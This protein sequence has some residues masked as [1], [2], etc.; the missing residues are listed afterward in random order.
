MI[1]LLS[2]AFIPLAI[3]QQAPSQPVL[4]I[5]QNY[6]LIEDYQ[7]GV[8]T[9]QSHTERIFDGTD[10]KDFIVYDRS[11]IIQVE[12]N[13]IGSLVYD[14][15]NCSYSI[16][17]NGYVTSGTQIIPSVSWMPRI[18]EVGTD[19]YS[20]MT[21]LFNQQCD[22]QVR[23]GEDWVK[24]TSIK[25][26]TEDLPPLVVQ[27]LNGTSSTYSQGVTQVATTTQT[28]D[29]RTDNGIKE[30]V[31][32]F[33]GNPE[34]SN[35]KF[36]LTQTIH[37]GAEITLAD[38]TYD[39]AAASGT[40]LDRNW[41]ENNEAEIFE[42]AD[43]LNYDMDVGFEQFNALQ[44]IDDGGVYKVALDYSVNVVTPIGSYYEVDPTLSYADESSW[45]RVRTDAHTGS[46][47]NGVGTTLFTGGEE[48]SKGASGSSD[49]C[50]WIGYE[51]DISSIS[52]SAVVSDVQFRI[53]NSNAQGDGQNETCYLVPFDEA[54]STIS[55]A[56]LMTDI[57][58][59]TP[60]AS[61]TFCQSAN[62]QTVFDLGTTA[63]TDA[64]NDLSSGGLFGVGVRYSTVRDSVDNNA[65]PLSNSQL[66]IEYSIPTQ[67]SAPANLSAVSGI[68]IA[69]DWDASTD[70][71]GAATGDMT[72][73][74][75][76]ADYE[77][78]QQ[79]LPINAGSDSAVNM[80]TNVLLYHLDEVESV[81]GG[82]TT[83]TFNDEFTSDQGWTITQA[84]SGADLNG[85]NS[86]TLEFYMP[87]SNG[88]GT[89]YQDYIDLGVTLSTDYIV[90]F[91][92]NHD[93]V[94]ST[95]TFIGVS[96]SPTS[97]PTGGNENFQGVKMVSNAGTPYWQGLAS[98]GVCIGSCYTSWAG[99]E[100]SSGGNWASSTTD[101]MEIIASGGTLTVSEYADNTYSGTPTS[102]T[103]TITSGNQGGQTYFVIKN[104]EFGS[105]WG[106]GA[107]GGYIDNLRVYNGATSVTPHTTTYQIE[108]TSGANNDSENPQVTGMVSSDAQWDNLGTS[109]SDS[110]SG[111]VTKSGSD[112]WSS[113]A[114]TTQT[115][116][117]GSP[118]SVETSATSTHWVFGIMREND[119]TAW[120][121]NNGGQFQIHP[122]W[123]N[124]F[125]V[126]DYS[127]S[128]SQTWSFS[129]WS[130]SDVFKIEVDA[131]GN[132]TFYQNGNQLATSGIGQ[133]TG[134]YVGGVGL[135]TSGVATMDVASEI[136]VNP[137][138]STGTIANQIDAPQLT[139]KSTSLYD[140]TDSHTVG[141][142]TSAITTSIVY[143]E[144]TSDTTEN[145]HIQVASVDQSGGNSEDSRAGVKI[146]SSSHGIVG[147][148]L[149]KVVFKLRNPFSS[150]STYEITAKVWDSSGSV[151]GTSG[152]IVTL[153]QLQTS[154][155]GDA[156]KV[157][158]IFDP[159]VT[160]AQDDI[161]GIE[162][163]SGTTDTDS[164][165]F[166]INTSNV[167]SDSELISYRNGAWQSGN[168]F[169]N[170]DPYMI[171][172]TGSSPS[173]TGT[174]LSFENTAGDTI[175]YEI[176]TDKVRVKKASST[177][178]MDT[179]S[180]TLGADLH[181]YGSTTMRGEKAETSSSALIG[182]TAQ[183][184][185]FKLK[186]VGSPT[187]TATV[188]V[189][190]DGG[191]LRE[192]VGTLDVSTV[193]STYTD[194]TFENPTASYT[195]VENDQIVIHYSGS[196]SN[197]ISTVRINSDVFDGSN[198]VRSYHDG[199]WVFD[200]GTDMVMKVE[201]SSTTNIIEAT[202]QT[203]STSTPSHIQF[204]RG[205]VN[206]WSIYLDG[207]SVATATDSTSLGTANSLSP[208]I[209]YDFEQTSS[210]LTN[211][212]TGSNLDGTNNGATTGSTGILGSSWDFD[213]SNDYVNTS[214]NALSSTHSAFTL[215]GWL[216]PSSTATTYALCLSP[217]DGNTNNFHCVQT[218]SNGVFQA[219]VGDNSVQTSCNGSTSYSTSAWSHVAVQYDGSSTKLFV[220]GVLD[221]TSSSTPSGSYTQDTKV[222]LAR[223][224]TSGQTFYGGLID[225]VLVFN[226][227]ISADT[228]SEIYNSGNGQSSFTPSYYIGQSPTGTNTLPSL[229]EFY[230]FTSDKSSE[231][232]D[233]YDRGSNQF[234]Q[235]GSTTGSDTDHDD[236]S[237]LVAGTDYYHRIISNNGAFDSVPSAVV[238]S[239]A[240]LP[241]D[242][243]TSLTAAIN[244]PNTAPLDITLNWNAGASGGTGTFQNYI[245]IRSP[246]STFTSVSTVGTPTATT[247]TDTVPS[248]GGTFYY[249]VS[250]QSTHGGS[251][252][253]SP[254][255]ITTPTVPDAPTISLAINNPNPSPLT[256]TTTFTPP[257]N[258][259]G[260]AITGYH[261]F[262]SGD[263]VTY[264]QVA[265]GVSSPYDY[266]VSTSGTHYFK[267][268]AVNLIG[269]S[270]DSAAQSIATP[271]IPGVPQSLT[272]TI[273]D[274][275]ASPYNVQLDWTAP[276]SDGG[277]AVTGYKLYRDGVLVSTLGVVLT[278]TDTATSNASTNFVYTV[279]AL[280]NI[281][282]SATAASYTWT[283]LAVPPAPASLTVTLPDVDTAPFTVTLDW[284]AP[285]TSDSAVTGYLVHRDS[286]L[287]ATLGN[288]LTVQD[289]TPSNA[290]TN[291][292]YDVY[293]ISNVGTGTASVQQ[294]WTS[295]AVPSQVQ[296]LSGSMV[297]SNVALTWATPASDSAI[298]E[299][300]L[301]RGQSLILTGND[302]TAY[303]DS[304]NIIPD[305]SLTYTIKA[306]SLVGTGLISNPT[307]VSTGSAAVLDLSATNVIG[308]SLVLTWTEPIY[309]AGTVQGYMVNYTS[310]GGDPNIILVANTGTPTTVLPLSSLNYNANYTWSVGVITPSG[311]NADGNWY[312]VTM[313]EDSSITSYNVTSGFDLDATNTMELEQIKF[314]RIDN[315]DGTTTLEVTHPV[316]Y[317][318]NCNL[319]SKFAMTNANY[320][321]L[322]TTI[323]DGND[324]KA[325]FIFTGLENEIITVKCTDTVYSPYDSAD[326]I[327]T[328]NEF[329][330]LQQIQN[331][332]NGT[333]G[334]SGMFGVIDL[335]SL[336]AIL[337]TMIGFNRVNHVVG[338]VFA[339]IMFGV[340][341]WFEIVQWTTVF[342]GLLATSLMLFIVTQRK[343]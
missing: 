318:L 9:W 303:T 275:D 170:Y 196:S 82:G 40:V 261:L 329:P 148:D 47:C 297:N 142:W 249:K 127:G 274:A 10:W 291:F 60:Y 177:T 41:I 213:G 75:E 188:K 51:F 193:A 267:A 105:G 325:S 331:F 326:Y 300:K 106:S 198:S 258:V 296:G 131:S 168:N 112:S 42:I 211:Q 62:S 185:T 226:T 108:D 269:A 158:Y 130:S 141:G 286:V 87:Y 340:L 264:T 280:N 164:V 218:K 337:I 200:S 11:N 83:P 255:N 109:M 224:G 206:D 25:I 225:Q 282:E 299:Y 26:Q 4:T 31:S 135:Y 116:T 195:M 319:A 5:G 56:D 284:T 209:H 173:A 65:I 85:V 199:S 156:N 53:D 186:A 17:E 251:A 316:Q 298:T 23:Q 204:N 44:V 220:D 304:N 231:A 34:W 265:T 271:T 144:I 184:V 134:T 327:L 321:N 77:F 190:S 58:T 128:S 187:G 1:P 140:G 104:Q 97:A 174:M 103:S 137:T 289:T 239:T 336:G 133:A 29:I 107:N 79:P 317:D 138:F 67:P 157:E 309:S 257:G 147:E 110:G 343:K 30:T 72:Y 229:D 216:K 146:T 160:I 241:P 323:I 114:D 277:S 183:K 99:G 162:P 194:Y 263:D 292:V 18:A 152:T 335:I 78:A 217:E 124:T 37:T 313:G 214:T 182:A 189:V 330:L 136:M 113:V 236:N 203:I 315:A 320:T 171:T 43:S 28:L 268:Q 253:S 167:V 59:N 16:Y 272:V 240:G 244:N 179:L 48:I 50:R 15:N 338:G 293:A 145:D 35:H 8:A 322:P 247:F 175:S 90:R 223:Q 153:D 207:T 314:D 86:N 45:Q 149:A 3:A 93:Q 332:S 32:V 181:L 250:S 73:K 6:D 61:S 178:H 166:R 245:V 237:S 305:Q 273:P 70:L 270:V 161:I 111:T 81:T 151:K 2:V 312:N 254:V 215:M 39:V 126:Y 248:G 24:I 74:V 308:N 63:D 52:S 49:D 227:A 57:E 7:L 252:N 102:V 310:P 132:P 64:T 143:S 101:Y 84:G 219:T 165:V 20:E 38:Q 176:E 122:T 328:Q 311:T 266:T 208:L 246:D 159:A 89:L 119:H 121:S 19:N 191:T 172:Y 288:V 163:Q 232:S 242:A 234:A 256:I 205:T 69:L 54:L 68:P 96:D 76:R 139:V 233:I 118:F 306:S 117:V 324:K 302:T 281:G 95:I 180:E 55:A 22:V 13:S 278:G 259:G 27:H 21:D 66:Q 46:T 71:G 125:D 36:A 222:N 202:G 342:T 14:K 80:S 210:T 123:S 307:V 260:S 287:I 285:S 100:S 155:V 221:C 295:P 301:Y 150:A 279:K 91:E 339:V 98:N 92:V 88:G 115:F 243:P 276:A 341:G 238:Q 169:N 201:S 212:G 235:V 290:S 294:T 262:H 333:Y 129:G 334:T 230:I 228:V 283:S 154:W 197:Y 33:N 120:G 192:T 94:D 12:S